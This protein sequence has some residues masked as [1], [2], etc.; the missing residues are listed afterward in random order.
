VRARERI[1]GRLG[2]LGDAARE[3]GCERELEGVRRL[4]EANGAERQ[5]RAGDAHGAAAWLAAVYPPLP[6]AVSG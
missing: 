3:L 5:R 1:A 4:L 6:S 2:E